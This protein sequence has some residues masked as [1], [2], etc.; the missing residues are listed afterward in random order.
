MDVRQ[1]PKANEK[2]VAPDCQQAEMKH[3]GHAKRCQ[4]RD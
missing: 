1:C 3:R 2:D 4:H